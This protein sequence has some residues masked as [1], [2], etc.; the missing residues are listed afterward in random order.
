VKAIGDVLAFVLGG[1]V[2]SKIIGQSKLNAEWEDI[3]KEAF[4]KR[5][6]KK[7][8]EDGFSRGVLENDRITAQK[9]AC[10]S[11][12]S[13]IKNNVLYIEIHHQGWA[14]ILQTIQSGILSIIN[15]RYSDVSVNAVAFLLVDDCQHLNNE[16]ENE[17]EKSSERRMNNEFNN[18][19]YAKIKDEKLR[20]ILMNLESEISLKANPDSRNT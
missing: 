15:K 3:V 8:D 13:Y 9:A 7:N 4:M 10:H 17:A 5:G 11:K 2:Q 14:Q 12:V 20:N 19:R 18:E 6:N 16:E 1:K